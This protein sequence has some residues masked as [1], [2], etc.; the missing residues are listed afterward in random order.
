MRGY[1]AIIGNPVKLFHRNVLNGSRKG[2]K[3]IAGE[4]SL[5]TICPIQNI[6]RIHNICP[7]P[8]TSIRENKIQKGW[9]DLKEL[10]GFHYWHSRVR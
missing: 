1:D 5:Q 6:S 2:G 8:P 10:R 9:R 4:L 7:V 3:V